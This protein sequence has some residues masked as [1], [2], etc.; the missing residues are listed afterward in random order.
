VIGLVMLTLSFAGMAAVAAQGSYDYF[1]ELTVLGRV[2]SGLIIA[3]LNQAAMRGI[4]GAL[5]AQSSMF[6]GYVRQLGGVLGVAAV[7]VYVAWR[8]AG[9][10]G[11]S[12]EAHAHAFAEAFLISTLIFALATLA[13]WRM[14]SPS[15]H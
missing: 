7:A 10:G 2:G 3:S 4:H 14:K 6:I 15:P 1:I 9:L 13:A 8:S 5:L 11:S 12:M